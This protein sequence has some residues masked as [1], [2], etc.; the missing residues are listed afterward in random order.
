MR[1]IFAAILNNGT[2][3]TAKG[4][5]VVKPGIGSI[6]TRVT[7]FLPTSLPDYVEDDDELARVLERHMTDVTQDDIEA[8]TNT[9]SES[10]VNGTSIYRGTVIPS[11]N[12]ATE[13]AVSRLER[14]LNTNDDD[15]FTVT[16][17]NLPEVLTSSS[18]FDM[19][20][21]KG[22]R[23]LSMERIQ[24]VQGIN[25]SDL[26]TMMMEEIT[27]KST[28]AWLLTLGRD[29]MVYLLSL[30]WSA[31]KF[32][33]DGVMPGR[34][35]H[36]L[37]KAIMGLVSADFLYNT[38]PLDTVNM[39]LTSYK[40][41]LRERMD[42]YGTNIYRMVTRFNHDVSI[43]KVIISEAPSAKA[44]LVAGPAYDA[45]L[46]SK[47]SIEALYGRMLTTDKTY[48]IKALDGKAM[49]YVARW[50]KHNR[51]MSLHRN[52]RSNEQLRRIIMST[53]ERREL[54]D[55]EKEYA[56]VDPEWPEKSL[57]AAK[58]M[59]EH[60]EESELVNIKL[61]MTKIMCKTLF[62]FTSAYEFLM[63]MESSKKA[64]PT[65]ETDE[66]VEMAMIDVMT[67]LIVESVEIG[68]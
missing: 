18:V 42:I 37:D 53:L 25:P 20:E 35:D 65:A 32:S 55:I 15:S 22:K 5:L 54:T 24:P 56:T 9:L 43:N 66:L 41:M 8:V 49:D 62:R 31:G 10:L 52:K 7:D 12:D 36:E 38:D 58:E 29:Y 68:E 23:F 2:I 48:S 16:I 63:A 28:K 60:I 44:V 17:M 14:Y 45:W 67:K 57:H 4:P 11:I 40:T 30:V 50:T 34:L 51:M 3:Q 19:A 59:A 47:G 26:A 64:V 21:Y 61:A 33:M 1:E 6:W 13:E 27:D 46:E 39:G